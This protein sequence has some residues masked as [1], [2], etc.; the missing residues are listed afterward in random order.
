MSTILFVYFFT[1]CVLIWLWDALATYVIAQILGVEVLAVGLFVGPKLIGIQLWK[2][3][4]AIHAFPLGSFVRMK[5]Q[6]EKDLLPPP[7]SFPSLSF[8]LRAFLI[9]ASNSL[10]L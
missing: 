7:K 9:L 10:L 2:T 6:E 1:S 3:Q 4:F 8:A 5:G